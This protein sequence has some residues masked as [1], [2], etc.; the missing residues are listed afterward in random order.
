MGNAWGVI[1]CAKVSNELRL[2]LIQWRLI[3]HGLAWR[4][5]GPFCP[6]DLGSQLA[7]GASGECQVRT[8]ILFQPHGR[9]DAQPARRRLWLTC[10]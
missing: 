1:G 2:N 10:V 7:I 6:V 4:L 3:R 5:C 8:T 9:G